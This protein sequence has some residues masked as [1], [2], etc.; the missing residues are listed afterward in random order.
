MVKKANRVHTPS[1][2]ALLPKSREVLQH[3]VRLC[4]CCVCNKRSTELR[5]D[6]TRM[7]SK[8][9]NTG[10]IRRPPIT[11]FLSHPVPISIS[12]FL[13]FSLTP[14]FSLF[15]LLFLNISSPLSAFLPLTTRFSLLFDHDYLPPILC[16]PLSFLFSII[17]FSPYWISICP[18]TAYA[19]FVPA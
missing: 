13:S 16:V 7:H 3:L 18:L 9:F 8:D 10:I 11:P 19:L 1:S 15:L 6:S 17:L 14:S 2:F 4:V 12:L 5:T